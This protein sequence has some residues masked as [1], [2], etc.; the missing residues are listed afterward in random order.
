VSLAAAAAEAGIGQ[1]EFARQAYVHG[2]KPP[3]DPAMAA[4]ELL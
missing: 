1:A 2:L 3:F 4:E